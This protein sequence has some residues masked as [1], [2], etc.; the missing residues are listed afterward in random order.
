MRRRKDHGIADVIIGTFIINSIQYFSLINVGLTHSYVACSMFDKLGIIIEDIV[1]DVIM[2][3]PLGQSMF[4]NKIFRIS[5]LEI[6]GELI[7]T[8][9]IELPFVEFDLILS[10]N[11]LKEIRV[12]LDC[13]TK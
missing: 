7:L 8:D 10:M 11:W 4:L 1:S 9:L 5:S 2:L 3:S 6:Q 12:S 13:D